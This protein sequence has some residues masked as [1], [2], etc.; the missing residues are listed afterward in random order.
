MHPSIF[1]LNILLQTLQNG[2]QYHQ[3]HE[4][5]KMVAQRVVDLLANSTK[6]QTQEWGNWNHLAEQII[7]NLNIFIHTEPEKLDIKQ[8]KLQYTKWLVEINS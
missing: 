5:N 2:L 3:N 6:G 7:N 8:F 1:V 4:F